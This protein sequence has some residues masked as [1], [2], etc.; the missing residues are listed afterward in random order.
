MAGWTGP[1]WTSGRRSITGR[2][3]ILYVARHLPPPGR[4][5]LSDAYLTELREL[6]V[7]AGGPDARLVL[8]DAGSPAGGRRTA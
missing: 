7:A 2:S 8:V 6:I 3:G 1:A 4:D 5:G